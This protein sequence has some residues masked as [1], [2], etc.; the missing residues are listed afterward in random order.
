VPAKADN[1]LPIVPGW[2]CIATLYQPKK[3]IPDGSWT[4]PKPQAVE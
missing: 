3:E 2:N 1:F 4:F